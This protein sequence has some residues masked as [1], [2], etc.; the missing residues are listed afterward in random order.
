MNPLFE[1]VEVEGVGVLYLA[2]EEPLVVALEVVTD[3][4]PVEDSVDHMTAKQPQFDLI[5][6]M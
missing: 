1:I 2:C 6:C 5:A 3:L 4:L